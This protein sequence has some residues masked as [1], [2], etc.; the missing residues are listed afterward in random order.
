MIELIL[1]YILNGAIQVEKYTDAADACPAF[2][3]VKKDDPRARLVKENENV[4]RICGMGVCSPSVV[5][6]DVSCVK[7]EQY[8]VEPK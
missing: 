1:V 3:K 4:L 6:S 5:M 7:K 8:V 2:E